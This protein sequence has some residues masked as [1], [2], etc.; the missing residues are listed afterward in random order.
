M[1]LPGF[2]KARLD[3]MRAVMAGHV[4]RGGVPGIVTLVSRR[5]ETHVDAF[6]TKAVGESDP[7][8]RDTIFRIA[9]MTKPI[10]AAATMIMVEECKLTQSLWTS[11]SPPV[12]Y[13]DFW[14]SA[15]QAIDD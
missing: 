15:Y 10:T 13:L 5:G 6:G 2:S 9:S 14:T 1:T 11:P 4:G 8:R 7:M 12:V 3:R